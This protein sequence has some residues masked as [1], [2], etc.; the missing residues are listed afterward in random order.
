MAMGEGVVVPSVSGSLLTID[1]SIWCSLSLFWLATLWSLGLT[2]KPIFQYTQPRINPW[3]ARLVI[4][5]QRA[6][7]PVHRIGWYMYRFS[8]V[9]SGE[10]IVGHEPGR[11]PGTPFLFTGAMH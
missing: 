4:R 10:R 3:Y 7:V 11:P 1:A 8:A 5:V 2:H 6:L 9:F